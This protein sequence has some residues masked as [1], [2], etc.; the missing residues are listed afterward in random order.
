MVLLTKFKLYQAL[1]ELG[2]LFIIQIYTFDE[3]HDI[4]AS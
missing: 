4:F 2:L 3:V 1:A